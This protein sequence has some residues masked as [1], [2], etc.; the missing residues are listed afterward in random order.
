M[1]GKHYIGRKVSHIEKYDETA[2]ISGVALLLDENNQILAGDQNGFVLDIT[3]PY[4]TQ[5]MAN[6]ILAKV[7]GHTYKGFRAENAP[8]AIDAELG[9]AVTVDG[10]YSVLAQRSVNFGPGH[11]SEIAAP[12]ENELRHEYNYLTP[13]EKLQRRIAGTNSRITKT[14]EQIRLEVEDEVKGLSSSLEL[15]ATTLTAK[16]NDVN[17]GLS[18]KIEQTTSTL[19]TQINNTKTGLSS[20]IK[21]TADTLTS[22]IT[23]VD[24][25]VTTV[26]QSVDGLSTRVSG[27]NG[28]YSTLQQKVD[29]FTLSVNNG[30]TSSTI[31][32]KAGSATISSQTITMNGLV[33]FTGLS[34]GTT[35]IDGACIKTGTI[36]ADRLNL[37]GEIVFTDLDWNAQ[38][39]INGAASN[40]ADAL[41]GVD[42]LA[43]GDFYGGTFINGQ[44]IYSPIIRSQHFEVHSG[45]A[46]G[47]FDLYGGY[48]GDE[49]HM[50]RIEYK[51]TDDVPY[52]RIYSPA[53]AYIDIGNSNA[54]IAFYGNI[55]FSAADV[56][57][58]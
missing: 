41:S 13:T 56:T 24:G 23:A 16:I 5:A 19:T 4:G 39:K 57:G 3:C 51:P 44:T 35:T 36:D 27:L 43:N 45:N 29:S 53:Q 49:Y 6:D 2:P 28:K 9:D 37:T 42:N 7:R 21:Q 22:K 33:T 48:R 58:L 20:E 11:F 32:L 30:S 38:N 1:N 10:L 8:L 52:V 15:T 17:N 54:N 34:Q 47:S 55:D 26:K 25:R 18:S 14:A 12:G 50:L 31:T 46:L 40:A